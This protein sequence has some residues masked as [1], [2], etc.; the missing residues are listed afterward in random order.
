MTNILGVPWQ[1]M[2]L[3][4]RA[5]EVFV[6]RRPYL[7]LLVAVGGGWLAV[8]LGVIEEG[9]YLYAGA[10]GVGLL[11]RILWDLWNAAKRFGSYS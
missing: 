1:V 2:G 8:R 4:A 5:W 10:L 11:A 3:I 6:N 7:C 9:R